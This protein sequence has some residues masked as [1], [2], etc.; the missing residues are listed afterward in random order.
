[1]YSLKEN[2]IIRII[3]ACELY[4]NST[5]SEYVWDQY[6][7]IIEKLKL[8]LDQNFPDERKKNVQYTN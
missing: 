7:S 3:A 4:K 5:G 6:D 1:M 8:Y 2:D